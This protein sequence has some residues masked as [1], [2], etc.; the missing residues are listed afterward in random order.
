[1][2]SELRR[3]DLSFDIKLP[4]FI[5]LRDQYSDCYNFKCDPALITF[6]FPKQFFEI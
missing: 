5:S 3:A 2:I 6:P 4:S 1:M